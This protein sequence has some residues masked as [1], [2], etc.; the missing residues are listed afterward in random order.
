[1]TTKELRQ[2]LDWSDEGLLEAKID[3]SWQPHSADKFISTRESFHVF[4]RK[5][6]PTLRPWK[7]EEVP[8][9]AQVRTKEGNGIW[10]KGIIANITLHRILIAPG[11]NPSWQHLL[12]AWE[13]SLDH[14]K[15]WLPCGV[16]DN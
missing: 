13:H 10:H 3:G 14:G 15:T 16:Y 6:T 2:V 5:P 12:E 4:R 1:M 7:P 11:N 8:V 9:G